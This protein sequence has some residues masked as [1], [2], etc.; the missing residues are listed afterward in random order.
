MMFLAKVKGLVGRITTNKQL[1]RNVS[2]L[3]GDKILR[4]SISLVVVVWTARYL[5]PSNNGVLAYAISFT[6]LFGALVSFGMGTI[7]VTDINKNP[8]KENA[9]LGTALAVMSAGAIITLALQSIII[10]QL[11]PGDSLMH[12]LVLVI[13]I[14]YLFRPLHSAVSIYYQ[15]KPEYKPIVVTSNVAF[16]VTSLLK[17]LALANSSSLQVLAAISS[18]EAILLCLLL[19]VY[20]QRTTNG[21]KQWGIDKNIFSNYLRQGLPLFISTL[22]SDVYMRIDLVMVGDLHSNYEAGIYSIAVTMVQI[23]YFLPVVVYNSIFPDLIRLEKSNHELF[24]QK[25]QKFYNYM[26]I[27]SYAICIPVALFSGYIISLLFGAAYKDSGLILSI[28]IWG[29]ALVNFGMPRNAYMFSKGYYTLHLKITITGGIMNILLNLLLIPQ[30]GALGATIATL[31]TYF[32]T[33]IVSNF[34]YKQIKENGHMIFKA[35]LKP[36]L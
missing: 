19:T 18:F 27:L 29:A 2:W 14:S 9:I 26:G 33:N 24:L 12:T 1:I 6:S 22:S 10:F 15:A 3:L 25:L 35:M 20:Y 16:I 8:E 36:A 32:Y 23:W 5:G 17:V 13:G 7:A 31:I 28:L 11:R 34:F 21:F 30:M 4:Y